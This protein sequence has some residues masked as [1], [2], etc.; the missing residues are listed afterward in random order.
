MWQEAERFRL[1]SW[2]NDMCGII[3]VISRN[4]NH[5]VSKAGLE[6]AVKTQ[7]HRGIDGSRVFVDRSETF[8]LGHNLLSFTD[9]S[10][11]HQP[12]TSADGR[13]FLVCN[14]EFYD[15]DQTLKAVPP[16]LDIASQSDSKLPLLLYQLYGL[17]MF[18][19]LEGEFAF[20][21]HDAQQGRLVLARDRFGIKPMYYFLDN[22]KIVFSSEIKGIFSYL[23]YATSM[24]FPMALEAAVLGV[25]V[26]HSLF[27]GVRQLEPGSFLVFD[28][29]GVSERRYFQS[30]FE[31]PTRPISDGEF[32]EQLRTTLTEAVK[33]RIP[34]FTKPICYLSGGLDSSILYSL[35]AKQMTSPPTAYSIKFLSDTRDDEAAE[36]SQ[37]V[38]AFGGRHEVVE[39]SEKN[40]ANSFQECLWHTESPISNHHSTAKFL[41]NR[42]VSSHG[43]R[44]AFSGEGCDELFFGY[45]SFID[46]F[47]QSADPLQR[48]IWGAERSSLTRSSLVGGRPDSV[49]GLDR[50][51]STIGFVPTFLA[52]VLSS[53]LLAHYI[54]S[55]GVQSEIVRCLT[56]MLNQ[57]YPDLQNMEPVARTAV[58]W[59][60]FVFPNYHLACLGDRVEMASSVEARLPFLDT[61]IA[62]LAFS[63]PTK[64]K[65]GTGLGKQVLRNAVKGLVSDEILRRPKRAF[66]APDYAASSEWNKLRLEVIG[67]ASGLDDFLNQPSLVSQLSSN[68]RDPAQDRLMNRIVSLKILEQVFGSRN[69]AES[70]KE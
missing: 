13:Y 65:V 68:V 66:L 15:Y 52:S 5:R 6:R 51:S 29:Q 48:Q 38:N 25:P 22:E 60:K 36:A 53:N 20:A 49:A 62:Q 40:L 14:G 3:G 37:L 43:M 42:V 58:I 4:N 10:S 12:L 46:D 1:Y 27:Q 8:G 34:K 54:K 69:W 35:L 50:L 61:G 19:H 55:N 45:P 41:L 31:S 16:E 23:G 32:D 39:L 33:K 64:I 56:V 7:Q 24:D 57:S 28:E 30:Q 11:G 21:I 26:G 2:R 17:D 18:R 63:I 47:F 59:L 67:S 44:C 9:L 70:P